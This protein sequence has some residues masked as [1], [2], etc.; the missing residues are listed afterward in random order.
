[1]FRNREDFVFTPYKRLE[2]RQAIIQMYMNYL[3][4]LLAE[5]APSPQCYDSIT[6]ALCVHYFLP[7]GNSSSIQLPQFLCPET[8]RYIVDNLCRDEWLNLVEQRKKQPAKYQNVT[9]LDLPVCDNTALIFGSL[10][11]PNDCCSSGNVTIPMTQCF[12]AIGFSVG[13][14]TLLIIVAIV[15]LLCLI[16]AI[17]FW[18]KRKNKELQDSRCSEVYSRENAK[19][20]FF[21]V[22]LC[23][24]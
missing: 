19:H 5:S 9:E 13:G 17:I 24:D 6:K 12:V 8:C 3:A 23:I 7:C 4:S 1:M 10:N 21:A 18:K 20:Y 2:G 15:T 16:T 22:I 14:V 11:L